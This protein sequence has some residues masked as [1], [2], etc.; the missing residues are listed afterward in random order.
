MKGWLSVAAFAS[1]AFAA[2]L[3]GQS[4]GAKT[5]LKRAVSPDGTC[6]GSAGYT[7]SASSYRCCSQWGWCGDDEEHCGRCILSNRH[8]SSRR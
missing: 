5:L 7:C 8:P 6:G 1:V 4:G 2:A 3:P